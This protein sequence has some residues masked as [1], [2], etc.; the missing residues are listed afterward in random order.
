MVVTHNPSLALWIAVVISGVVEKGFFKKERG[1][2]PIT[3]RLTK[4]V[5]KDSFENHQNY[6]YIYIYNIGTLAGYRPP[7]QGR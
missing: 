7:A 1:S 6:E 4:M 2:T 5:R 3:S